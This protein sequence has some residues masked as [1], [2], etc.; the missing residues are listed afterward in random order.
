MHSISLHM[1][2]YQIH[3]F[4]YFVTI[5][6]VAL[7]SSCDTANFENSNQEHSITTYK[8]SAIA[9]DAHCGED[10]L[11]FD[12]IA[13]KN[14]PVGSVRVNN[15]TD[16]LIVVYQTSGS[17]VLTKTALNIHTNSPTSRGVI[18]KY[19]YGASNLV[20]SSYYRVSI[21]LDE[22]GASPED[23]IYLQAFADVS[24]ID[25]S[26]QEGAFAG[27]IIHDKKGAWYGVIDYTISSACIDLTDGLVAYYPY[28]GNYNDIS[29]N[30]YHGT[31]VGTVNF[32]DDRFGTANSAIVG[33]AGRV[34]S[35]KD[36]FTFAR[37]QKFSFSVW[38]TSSQPNTSGR[39]VSNECS[40]GNFRMGRSPSSVA[41]QYGDYIFL[42]I[43]L[44]TWTHIVY[45]Y[46]NRNEKVYLN[47]E[48][49]ATNYD[50][51]TEALN[52]NCSFTVGAK[53]SSAYDR[54]PG[55]IDDVGVWNRPLS[56]EEVTALYSGPS[57][58]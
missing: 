41:V 26:Q 37:N 55:L 32:T 4:N 36:V 1:K 28:N 7:M 14:I 27:S 51:V 56:Q 29:G 5:A 17:W 12:L 48:L 57:L 38:F 24:T 30:A 43:S 9:N 53:A 35:S 23:D 40:E 21:G 46:D 15:T 49:Q 47:G 45:T 50:V 20:G 33:G 18:G 54:W 58:Q 16:S 3:T 11:S 10:V 6:H 52:Q 44:N 13:G 8:S 42:P 34:T 19:P 31:P 2:T 25:G 22:I 39:I